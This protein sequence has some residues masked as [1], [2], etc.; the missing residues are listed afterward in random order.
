VAFEL[1]SIGENE[2]CVAEF[3]IVQKIE[4]SM[5][6]CCKYVLLT[7]FFYLELE[8]YLRKLRSKTEQKIDLTPTA[9]MNQAKL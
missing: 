2:C 5:R 8:F 4:E 9:N 6:R 1:R 3:G 7:F